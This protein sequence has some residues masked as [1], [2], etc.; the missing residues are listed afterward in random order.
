MTYETDDIT[1]HVTCL[2]DTLVHAYMTHFCTCLY[3]TR[4]HA[5]M[6]HLHMP[7]DED[8]A[9]KEVPRKALLP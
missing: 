2:H 4:A 7:A 3:D 6:T 1:S 5:Y 8:G 9:Q